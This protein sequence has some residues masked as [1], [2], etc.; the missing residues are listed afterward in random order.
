[1]KMI[2]KYMRLIIGLIVAPMVAAA[3]M[4]VLTHTYMHFGSS[5]PPIQLKYLLYEY[6]SSILIA[7][8]MVIPFAIPIYLVLAKFKKD[9]LSA[10]VGVGLIAG[11]ILSLLAAPGQQLADAIGICAIVTI[12]G[13]MTTIVFY[14]VSVRHGVSPKTEPVHAGDGQATAR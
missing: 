9:T 13:T 6:A 11:L 5:P 8:F 1:M 2:L 14:F 7:S 12:A 3:G 10:Y 4:C